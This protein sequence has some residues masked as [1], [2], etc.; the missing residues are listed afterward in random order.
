VGGATGE[1]DG[2]TQGTD[3]LSHGAIK[4]RRGEIVKPLR[5]VSSPKMQLE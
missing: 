1:E 5:I 3:G 4:A 2:A